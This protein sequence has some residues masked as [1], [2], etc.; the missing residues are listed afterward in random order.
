MIRLRHLA[1]NIGEPDN[2]YRAGGDDVVQH[3]A[4]T[5]GGELVDIADEPRINPGAEVLSHA[6]MVVGAEQRMN[7]DLNCWPWL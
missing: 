6:F 5:D 7:R 1:K 3:V 2:R 4:R